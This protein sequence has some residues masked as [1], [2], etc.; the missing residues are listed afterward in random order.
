[1]LILLL[2]FV[3][4][5]DCNHMND[6]KLAFRQLRKSPGFTL[7][8]VLT[9]ALGIG[10]NTAI[11]SVV[12]GVLLRPLPFPNAERLVRIYEALDENGARSATLNLSD[13]TVARF[14][15]F[16]RD[17]FEDVAGGTGGASV[18]SA[19]AGSPAQTVPAA[20]VTY[21]FF[22]VL[23][24]PPSQGRNFTREEGTDK[25]ANV[26]IIS[27]DFWRNTLNSRRD[28]LG[29]TIVIDGTP[30]TIIGV[31][32]KAFRHPYRAS[33]WLPLALEPDNPATINNHYLYGVARLRPGV[34]PVKAEEAVKRMCATI[35]R[36]DPNP[37][38]VRAAYIP[39]LRESFV[40]DLRPK[41]LVI[42]GAAVCALLIAAANFAGLLLARVI[43]REG[44]FALRAALGASRR[45]LVRQQLDPGAFARFG[46][47][48]AWSAHRILDHANAFR[49]E[50]GRRGRDRQ[51]DA[52]IRLRGATRSARVRVCCRCNDAG[53][54]GFWF[55]AGGARSAHRFA[56]RNERYVTRRN[57]RPQ[58][59]QIARFIRRDRARDCRCA[60]DSERH[61][62]AIFPE[63]DRGAMGL[64]DERPPRF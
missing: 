64:R 31:M 14:R 30:R 41:I 63:A 37:A 60:S 38:N 33:L 11:F 18:V 15:E 36:D 59:A 34:T 50:P 28:V 49:A 61:R 20:L 27:D 7:V 29:S 3:L 1:M 53:R 42:V 16:G 48:R 35:N 23:G 4:N 46:R 13:R 44:E 47:N 52:R 55:A 5:D 51:R 8:A 2:P 17:I 24:L 43:E 39:P 22:D 26:A 21:N 19:K 57:T 10:A 54:F 6:L 58:C 62:D 25:A 56:R 45:R 40:M 9:L 12:E 32:P